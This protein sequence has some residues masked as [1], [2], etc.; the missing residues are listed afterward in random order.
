VPQP[1]R[2]LPERVR[3]L[4]AVAAEHVAG[5]IEGGFGAIVCDRCGHVEHLTE[6]EATGVLG[7][8]FNQWGD[9][10]EGDL[11]PRCFADDP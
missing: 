10:P 7:D 11:C 3:N 5:E 6:A 8:R 9:G 2:D 4:R 1:S